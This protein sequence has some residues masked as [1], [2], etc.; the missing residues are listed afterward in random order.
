MPVRLYL[1]DG[2][3]IQDLVPPV[4]EDGKFIVCYIPSVLTDSPL[5]FD[6][7]DFIVA[8]HTL[9]HYLTAHL[10]QLFSPRTSG[11][12]LAFPL[13]QGIIMPPETEM[14]W[15]GAC[16]AGADGWVNVCVGLLR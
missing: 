14:A 7:V 12:N 5:C 13:I 1:P 16:L 10:P 4:L 8:P 6:A 15:L 11:P 2:P 9:A 3:V